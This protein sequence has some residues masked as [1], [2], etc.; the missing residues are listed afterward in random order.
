MDLEIVFNELS[1]E[2]SATDLSTAKQWMSEFIKTILAIKPPPGAKRKLRT[3]ND[4]N[5][6]LLAPDYTVARWR[7]DSNVDLE[8]R[9]FLRTLQ[10]KNDPPLLD[11]ADPGIEVSY[12]KKQAIGLYYAFVFNS[13]AISLK[14]SSEWDCSLI[15]LEVTAI[16]DDENL[17][18]TTESVIH[19][20]CSKHIQKHEEWIRDRI[21]IEVYDGLDLWNRKEELFP[22]LEFCENV[23]KQLQNLSNGESILK[24]IVKR[25]FELEEYCKSWTCGS[26]NLDIIPCKVTPESD[27][28]LKSLREKFT[29]I[30]PDGTERIFSWH[31]RMTPGAWRLHIY[32]S[33]ETQLEPRKIIIGYIGL[34]IQ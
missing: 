25:L 8:T 34:K 23:S 21:K 32:F 11:I 17:E 1:I 19:A 16:D 14:S 33:T 15:E 22:S 6:S 20:S 28:R 10:D 2:Q 7:N 13:L 18:T 29:F 30:C 12:Q 4:F 5:Y 9:R 26:F 27:S 31:V 24:Q 3:K